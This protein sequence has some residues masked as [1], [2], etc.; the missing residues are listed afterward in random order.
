MDQELIKLDQ[1]ND[2]A[3]KDCQIQ[4]VPRG[5]LPKADRPWG[6]SSGILGYK[7]AGV[8]EH[9]YCAWMAIQELKFV[10]FLRKRQNAKS[11]LKLKKHKK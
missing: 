8:K 7:V 3:E 4:F 2:K 11:M 6:P 1:V 10:E 9:P 5:R